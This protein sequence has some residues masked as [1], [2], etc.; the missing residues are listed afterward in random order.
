MVVRNVLVAVA[1]L[2]LVGVLL[3]SRFGRFLEVM[4]VAIVMAIPLGRVLWLIGR[5]WGQRDFRFVR[6]AVLLVVLVAV[7]PMLAL[8][9]N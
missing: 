8:L 9:G 4:A 5:W 1:V 3:P 7:G 2:A 6:W